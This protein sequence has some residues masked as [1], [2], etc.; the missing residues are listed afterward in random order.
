MEHTNV[1]DGNAL[2]DEVEINLSIVGTL[3][4]NGV[5][6]EVDSTDV[7]TVDQSDPQQ[8]VV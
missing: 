1:P 5:G 3:V 7:I 8:G 4:L 2:A 6:G